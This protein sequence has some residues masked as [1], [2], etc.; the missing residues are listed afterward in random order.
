M[1]D[2]GKLLRRT[3]RRIVGAARAEDRLTFAKLIRE[4]LQVDEGSVD[5]VQES[6]PMYDHVNVQAGLD[7]WLGESRRGHE[8]VGVVNFHHRDF[9]LSELMR[10]AAPHDVY[11]P[12]PG[13]V[14]RL[15]LACGPSGEV[16]PCVVCGVYLVGEGDRRAAL[17]F[18]MGEADRGRPSSTLEIAAD[19]PEFATAIAA[20]I[21]ELALKHNVYRRQVVSFSHISISSAACCCTALPASARRTRCG[22]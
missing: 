14:A 10:A 21:R 3:R 11:G 4:H 18:R 9:G 20:D 19:D 2:V 6:W 17:L 5:V 16:R 1:S 15:N 12:T 7:A 22:T 13:N 8:L